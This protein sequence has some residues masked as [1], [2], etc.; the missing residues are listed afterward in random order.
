MVVTAFP[1]G[2]SV[3]LA[4]AGGWLRGRT[5]RLTELI[6]WSGAVVLCPPGAA[7]LVDD[8]VRAFGLREGIT[9]LSI[10]Q[11][12]GSAHP[13]ASELW[14]GRATDAYVAG[15]AILFTLLAYRDRIRRVTPNAGMAAASAGTRSDPPAKQARSERPH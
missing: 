3:C 6:V 9:G 12:T 14:S 11:V 5:R 4:V 8:L 2:A 15:G 7:G 13:S 10:E 1:A